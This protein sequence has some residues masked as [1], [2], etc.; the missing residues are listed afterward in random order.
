MKIIRALY[1][2]SLFFVSHASYSQMSLTRSIFYA[3]AETCCAD[4][5]RT[6]INAMQDFRVLNVAI[7]VNLVQ[8]PESEKIAAAFTLPSFING[9]GYEIYITKKLQQ[10]LTHEQLMAVLGH[11]LGPTANSDSNRGIRSEYFADKFGVK[12]ILVL[13]IPSDAMITA[14]EKIFSQPSPI[15]DGDDKKN[16]KKRKR[17]LVKAIPLLEIFNALKMAEEAI[18]MREVYNNHCTLCHALTRNDPSDGHI[19]SVSKMLI[20]T[21]KADDASL[22]ERIQ[23]FA[24]DISDDEKRQLFSFIRSL[25]KSE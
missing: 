18:A 20:D 5:L 15:I 14:A 16:W 12:T 23:K 17:K 2:L 4:D 13:K 19:P 21:S 3:P 11:E 24:F 10:L 22:R 6:L 9:G 7:A 25:E 8:T 1:L